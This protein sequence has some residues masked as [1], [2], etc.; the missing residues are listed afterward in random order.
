M[1]ATVQIEADGGEQ[2]ARRLGDLLF[3]AMPRPGGSEHDWVRLIRAIAMGDQHA[4]RVLYDR[5]QPIVFV[6]AMRILNNRTCA[7]ELTLDVFYEI[8]R[9][10]ATYDAADGTVAGWI[11]NQ[12][13]SR[14]IECVQVSRQTRSPSGLEELRLALP[15][16]QLL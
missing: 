5:M 12:A 7:E 13:R 10:A 2:A 14:A 3:A 16:A 4:L 15:E 9:R 6:L 8:W 1:G 11:M